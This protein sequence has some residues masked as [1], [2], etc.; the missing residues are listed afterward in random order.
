MNKV[1]A[2]FTTLISL[3]AFAFNFS[4][5][6][7]GIGEGQTPKRTFKCSDVEMRVHIEKN[8]L[9]LRGGHYNCEGLSAEYP[10]STFNIQNGELIQEDKVVGSIDEQTILLK[11]PADGF[12]MTLNLYKGKLYFTESWIEG[13]KFLVI[14]AELNRN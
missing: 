3:N 4:G 9:I 6:W 10:Y 2:L 1:I 14:G 12:E 5:I 11:S 13:E 8:K 7:T